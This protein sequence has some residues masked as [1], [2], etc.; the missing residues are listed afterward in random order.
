MT[1][2]HR[3]MDEFGVLTN[4]KRSLIALIHS[5]V[6]WGIAMHGFVAPKFGIL[7]GLVATSDVILIAIYT[8]V[9]SV[10][11]WLVSVSRCGREKLYFALCASS[12]SFGLLRTIFGDSALPV[13]QYLRVIVL[14]SALAVCF[15][16]LRG[17]SIT[18]AEGILSE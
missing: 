5:L 8:I 7:R 3:P 10:L 9:A 2:E 11:T 4:R 16:I 14:T 17:F 15:V 12:A 1:L 13:A 6:F 18:A